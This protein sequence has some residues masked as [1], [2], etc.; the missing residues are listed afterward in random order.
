[1]KIILTSILTVLIAISAF[2]EIPADSVK[3]YFLAGR[4]LFD[5]ALA[6]NGAAMDGFIKKVKEAKAQ[7]N[8]NYLT[9]NGYASPE[10]ASDANQRLS[11]LRCDEISKYI[12][13]IF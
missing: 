8:I 7:D 4:R 10:G 2:G 11:G 12:I 1:M 6:N 3:V 5:P 9:I 13:G